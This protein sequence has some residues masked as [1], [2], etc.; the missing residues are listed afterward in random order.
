MVMAALG[1]RPAEFFAQAADG[2]PDVAADL[3][4]DPAS[5][6]G[7][8][9]L[10]LAQLIDPAPQLLSALLGDP[11]DLL[12]FHLVAGDQSLFL[13]PGQPGVDRPGRRRIDAE[14][15]VLQ[16]PDHLV[17]VPWRLV[18]QLEQ[19]QPQSAVA[20]HRTHRSSPS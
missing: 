4:R 5:G 19:I 8:L 2:V 6:R 1:R 10:K 14:E 13:Q 7:Q 18:E 16:Q 3:Q 12:A 17:A 9:I 20:E 15:P 11:V